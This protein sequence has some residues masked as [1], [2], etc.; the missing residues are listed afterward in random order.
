MPTGSQ[1]LR[2]LHSSAGDVAVAAF[3]VYVQIQSLSLPSKLDVT[4]L[5]FV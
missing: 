3:A 1:T 5:E 4:V 2:F